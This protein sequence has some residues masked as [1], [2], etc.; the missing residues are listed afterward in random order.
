MVAGGPAVDTFVVGEPEW[1]ERGVQL[2][3]GNV[4]RSR[5][6]WDRRHFD[7]DA[8]GVRGR[9]QQRW[10]CDLGTDGRAAIGEEEQ[11]EVTLSFRGADDCD[12]HFLYEGF[13][14]DGELG[15]H[16]AM[17]HVGVGRFASTATTRVAPACWAM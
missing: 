1:S 3:H 8:P 6:A 11:C 13:C 4:G 7:V 17:A 5:E 9:K 15:E 12:F 14:A 16:A 2:C 10:E